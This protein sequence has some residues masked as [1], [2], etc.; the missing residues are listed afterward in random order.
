M[1]LIHTSRDQPRPF[2]DPERTLDGSQRA[3]VALRKLETLWFNTGTQCN[4]TCENCYIESSPTNDALVYLSPDDVEPY[5]TEIA[6]LELPVRTLAYTGGEPF[7]NPAF[8]EILERGLD[9]GFE[10]LV[11]TN[12]MRPMM[13]HAEALLRLRRVHGDRL[14]LRVSVD[15]FDRRLHEEERGRQSWTPMLRGLKWLSAQGFRPGVAGRTRWG[16]DEATLR[17]GFARLFADEGI[18]VDAAD[19]SRLILFPEMDPEAEVPEI[20]TECWSILGK[21]PD[22]LM[23]ASSRMVERRRGSAAP[24]V[25]ACT[26]LPHD[27]RFDT[28]PRLADALGEVALNH[29]HC[30]RFCVLGGG[31]CSG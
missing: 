22:A 29:V 26:L 12:A 4:L 16:E 6:E 23:C 18:D 24:S 5:L 20:T 2:V 27:A 25:V 30:A 1:E 9:A 8:L 21:D 3:R 11:L 19:P 31:S 28:G 7:M 14:A 10:A 15:H 17:A 13:Q